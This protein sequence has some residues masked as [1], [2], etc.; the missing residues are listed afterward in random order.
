MNCMLIFLL[1]DLA[2]GDHLLKAMINDIQEQ[3]LKGLKIIAAMV[4]THM[5]F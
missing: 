2:R 5:W 3:A 1:L 4:G